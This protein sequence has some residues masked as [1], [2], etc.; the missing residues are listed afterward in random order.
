MIEI[1]IFLLRKGITRPEL[2]RRLGITNQ[3]LHDILHG[4]RRALH[5][6]SRLVHEFG[7]PEDL[8]EYQKKAA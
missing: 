3:Y 1:T 6:R 2:A 7:F 4:K 5:V 8:V